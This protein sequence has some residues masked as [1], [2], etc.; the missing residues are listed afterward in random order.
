MVW[1]GANREWQISDG[2]GL[3]ATFHV[4]SDPVTIEVLHALTDSGLHVLARAKGQG[5]SPTTIELLNQT[6]AGQSGSDTVTGTGN[7]VNM[8]GV[9]R[10]VD[11]P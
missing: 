8:E 10:T 2:S 5:A 7:A 3:R 1:D 9:W 4:S 11:C 6:Y